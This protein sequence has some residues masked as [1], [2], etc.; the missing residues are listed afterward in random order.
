MRDTR[1]LSL[2]SGADPLHQE[3]IAEAELGQQSTNIG[4]LPGAALQAVLS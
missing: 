4:S 3:V 2:L 1:V